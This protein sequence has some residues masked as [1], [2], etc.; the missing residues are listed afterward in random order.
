MKISVILRVAGRAIT[1]LVYIVGAI[2]CQTARLGLLEKARTRRARAEWLQRVA[3]QCVRILHLEVTQLGPLPSSGMLVSNHLGYLDIILLA[4]R[5]PC[6]FVSKVEVRAW[7]IFGHCAQLAGTIF[8]D[9]AHRGDVSSVIQQMRAALDDDVLVVLFPEGT[10]T[11]GASVLPF[12]SSLLEPAHQLGCHVTAAA[13][14][15]A[16]DEGSVPNEICYW[17][18]M[19]LVPH[20]LNI[21]SKSFI[22]CMLR[23]GVGRTRRGDRKSVAREL[24][25]EVAAL[26][27]ASTREL[28]MRAPQPIQE[29]LPIFSRRFPAA[30]KPQRS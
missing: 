13:I 9:R 7:P 17:R 18:D 25:D 26:H 12:R 11:G 16:L 8:V 30:A 10:S 28:A 24:H 23:C 2:L 15:Y 14:G 3:A 21:W 29:T 6:V 22:Y 5:Q 4:A 27:A 20:L 19:T 1:F